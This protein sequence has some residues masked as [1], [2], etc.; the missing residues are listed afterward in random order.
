MRWYVSKNDKIRDMI[1]YRSI[2]FI[3]YYYSF[4]TLID[5][6][7]FKIR[8]VGQHDVK[9]VFV[10]T[11]SIQTTRIELGMRTLL[12]RV[13]LMIGNQTFDVLF[14]IPDWLFIYIYSS[15]WYNGLY[16]WIIERDLHAFFANMPHPN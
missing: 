14:S 11:K 8:F 9:D 5:Y 1:L 12:E 16:H 6:I 13:P 7:H 10:I 3:L 4:Q 15:F 2:T